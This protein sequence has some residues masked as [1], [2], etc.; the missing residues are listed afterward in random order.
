MY[1]TKP[2]GLISAGKS[3]RADLS[4]RIRH[5]FLT[6]DRQVGK[7]TLLR[8]IIRQYPGKPGGF[9]TLRTGAF[10]PGKYS[11]HLFCAGD[12]PVPSEEDLLFV[13][14]QAGPDAAERFNEIGRAHV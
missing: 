7:S 6:G 5:V 4:A 3:G 11:V 10:L 14:G 8:K 2:G 12:E 9:F 13:C 1:I